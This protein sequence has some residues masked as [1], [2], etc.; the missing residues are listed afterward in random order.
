MLV[1]KKYEGLDGTELAISESQER[2]AV[3]V[4]AEKEAEFIKYADEEN[5]E[6][7][8]VAK[9]TDENRVKMYWRGK[10]ILDLVQRLPQYQRSTAV[11]GCSCK[12]FFE[13]GGSGACS[14]WIL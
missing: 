12:G 14:L 7:T 9:V 4:D 11:R 8:T 10:C 6:A 3:V 2:M 1:P 13:A 5:L